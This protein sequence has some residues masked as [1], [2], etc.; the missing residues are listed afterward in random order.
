MRV[1]RRLSLLGPFRAIK[2]MVEGIGGAAFFGSRLLM[3]ALVVDERRR[4][5]AGGRLCWYSM[6]E[7]GRGALIWRRHLL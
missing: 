7:G 5:V 3:L 2:E 6:E 1:R 4:K